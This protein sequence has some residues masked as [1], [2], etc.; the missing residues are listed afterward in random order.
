MVV[1]D[2]AYLLAKRGAFESIASKFAPT[3]GIRP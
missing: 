3:R 1:N 2:Y